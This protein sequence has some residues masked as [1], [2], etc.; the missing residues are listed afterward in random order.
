M[1]HH[2]FEETQ[3]SELSDSIHKTMFAL[4]AVTWNLN[5]AAFSRF[6]PNTGGV[7]YYFSPGAENIAKVHGAI[8]CEKPSL[9][10]AGG[11]FHGDQTVMKRL[12]G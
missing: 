3:T 4:L 1:W 8:A 11:L 6:D 2:L 12:W 10:E 5:A 9:K 7:H